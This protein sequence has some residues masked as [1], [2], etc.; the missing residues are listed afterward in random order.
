MEQQYIV[1]ARKYR[2]DTFESMVGQEALTK[3]LK[4]AILSNKMAHAYLFC[5]PRGVGKTTAARVLAKTINCL[6][7]TPQAEACNECESCKAFNE[8]RSMNIYELDAASNNSVDDIRQLIEQVSI[9]P[10][11]GKYKVYIIDEVHMLSQAAFNA[12][13][14]TLEEPPEYVIFILAT[15]EKHKIL[16]TI[17]SR[18]QIYDFKRIGLNDIIHH[19]E[20]VSS[21]EG[22]EAEK[23]ALGVIA[24]K[25]DGG[26][27]DAL[28]LFDRIASYSQGRI[29]YR[30]TVESL[31]ILD[32]EYYF[33]FIEYFLQG[34][35]RSILLT[36]NELLSKGFDGQI[37]INGL[38]SF[39][40]DLMVAQHP[41]TIALLEKPEHVKQRYLSVSAK[42][43]AAFLYQAIRA[44]NQCDQQYRASSNKRLL[45]ELC[46][47]SI[48]SLYSKALSGQVQ[49]ST[50]PAQEQQQG[51]AQTPTSARAMQTPQATPA[52]PSQPTANTPP[53]QSQPATGQG[54][55]TQQTTDT[56]PINDLSH[57]RQSAETPT[58][59]I[60][61]RGGTPPT[62]YKPEA[63]GRLSLRGLRNRQAET[64]KTSESEEIPEQSEA[65]SEEDMQI[66]WM[67]Y[68]KTEMSPEKL[69][70]RK[71]MEQNIPSLTAP[72]QALVTVPNNAVM[73]NLQEMLP[74]VLNYI[75]KEI[76]NTHLTMA[77]E[78]DQTAHEKVVYTSEERIELF[79][80][81]SPSFA[82]LYDRLKMRPL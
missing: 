61:N 14:K 75:R 4:S 8:Q 25:A 1:S 26:M 27:R 68:V 31:N 48:S 45:V 69:I 13:L 72:S 42:C 9:P 20:Y 29:T 74:Q 37:I 11:L 49:Q 62:D 38:A 55:G 5:G 73:E 15:T 17:L 81:K 70:M 66:A 56:A 82:K 80:K 47:M 52:T 51:G 60:F 53:P 76:K 3:T 54:T 46:L 28:S 43:P 64:E 2:P 16:P 65:F 22:L 34:D 36:L 59:P 7:R 19:L 50:S 57:S 39:M 18:C 41:E 21:S 6:N 35:Y 40:R 32:Y 30:Q 33:K 79:K 71:M 10:V 77:V 58:R 63:S 78:I 24:E 23:E 44:L 12:F 67:K